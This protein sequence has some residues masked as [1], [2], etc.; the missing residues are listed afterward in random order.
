[1]AVEHVFPPDYALPVEIKDKLQTPNRQGGIILGSLSHLLKNSIESFHANRCLL[2]IYK[3]RAY[4][5]LSGCSNYSILDLV[6]DAYNSH[7]GLAAPNVEVSWKG[8]TRLDEFYFDPRKYNPGL[9]RK[10]LTKLLVLFNDRHFNEET[11][12]GLNA[13]EREFL[14][15]NKL[16]PNPIT[17]RQSGFRPNVGFQILNEARNLEFITLPNPRIT[18]T[19]AMLSNENSTHVQAPSYIAELS[20]SNYQQYTKDRDS[21]FCRKGANKIDV[22]NLYDPTICIQGNTECPLLQICGARLLQQIKATTDIDKR[23]YELVQQLQ[24]KL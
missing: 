19:L 11:Y 13:F 20:H 17:D 23:D 14:I 15:S 21:A 1:M 22:L 2:N 3:I 16:V 18:Q 24:N 9:F 12:K 10:N 4:S 5:Y 6:K 7:R 8:S